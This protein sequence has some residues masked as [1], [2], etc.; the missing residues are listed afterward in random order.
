AAEVLL[1]GEV[2][3]NSAASTIYLLSDAFALAEPEVVRALEPAVAKLRAVHG[4]RVQS[5]TLALL[6]GEASAAEWDTWRDTYCLVQSAEIRSSLGA[7]IAAEL[8]QFGPATA[9]S[10][11]LVH[12]LDRTRVRAAIDLRER[13]YRALRRALGP[14][15]LVCLPTVPFP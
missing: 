6:C 14:R 3:D 4:P 12:D 5:I 8:P 13:R 1:A 15:D 11:K 2:E 10:F 9:G 7:W